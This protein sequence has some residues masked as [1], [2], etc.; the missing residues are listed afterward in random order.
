M[1]A[2]FLSLFYTAL[3]LKFQFCTV[4]Q[5]EGFSVYATL[6]A[7][8]VL[9]GIFLGFVWRAFSENMKWFRAMIEGVG[10]A[11]ILFAAVSVAEATL[12]DHFFETHRLPEEFSQLNGH[13]GVAVGRSVLKLVH[14]EEPDP[15]GA[16]AE[17]QLNQFCRLRHLSEVMKQ[18]NS[19][20][21]PTEDKIDC[22]TR[23]MGPVAEHGYWNHNTRKFF[24]D[25][26]MK[27]WPDSKNDE[28]VVGYAL[29]D[30]DL[31]GGRQSILRQV[32]MS[33]S[34]NEH[35]LFAQEKDELNNLLLTKEIFESVDHLLT[36]T[37]DGTQPPPYLVKFKDTETE[38]Q[39]KLARIPELQK[40][41]EQLSNRSKPL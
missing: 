36:D 7:F 2:L 24:F 33:E 27:A 30:L 21:A 22:L 11:L 14:A 35:Y 41:L 34:L 8:V 15:D 9:S 20:C 13:C 29:K 40:E 1:F 26:V 25:Q 38:L 19:F 37:P 17:F 18:K 12:S 32:G 10:I 4:D 16:L 3:A 28:A 5:K 6:G 39:A 23:W 31:E